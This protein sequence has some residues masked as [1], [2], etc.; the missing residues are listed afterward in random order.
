M[1]QNIDMSF[2]CLGDYVGVFVNWP[3]PDS[4]GVVASGWEPF[5]VFKAAVVTPAGGER[6]FDF[7]ATLW[8]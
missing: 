7:V 3:P 5:Y 4:T 6:K 2:L 1:P 8:F